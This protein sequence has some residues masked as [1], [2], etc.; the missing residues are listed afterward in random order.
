[1]AKGQKSCKKCGHTCGP[2]TKVCKCGQLFDIKTKEQKSEAVR[3]KHIEKAKKNPCSKLAEPPTVYAVSRHL[4]NDY[5]PLPKKLNEETIKEWVES[6]QD[7]T[8]RVG[9]SWGK[10]SKSAIYGVLQKTL[11]KVGLAT[12]IKLQKLVDKYYI[13]TSNDKEVKQ[14]INQRLHKWALIC[15][16]GE[17]GPLHGGPYRKKT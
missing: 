12:Q 8:V 9:Y 7:Y 17:Q 6:I 15:A 5:P 14:Q 1:M 2:R 10:Y 13:D 11:P 3:L 16:R 4:K